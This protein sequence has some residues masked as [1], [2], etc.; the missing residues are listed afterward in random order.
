M[1]MQQTTPSTSRSAFPWAIIFASLIVLAALLAL[2]T[3]QVKRLIWKQQLLETIDECTHAAPVS[4]AEMERLLASEGSVEYRPVTVAGT[5][6]HQGERHFLATYNGEPG[7]YVYTPLQLDD[8]RF[9]LVNR[10][11][12]PY[13]RKD[14]ATREEGQLDGPV[15]ISGLARDRLAERPSS[16][17]PD[18][19]LAKNIFFWKDLGVMATTAGLPDR[20]AVIPFFVD[21]DKAPNPGGLPIGGVT[22]VDLPNSH[23]QYAVTWYGLALALVLVVGAYVWRWRF[24]KDIAP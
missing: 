13:G 21:A 11:F 14:A 16:F 18:N 15:T 7:F 19:D 9:I 12:V 4:L 2:G 24:P 23:L 3:W 22:I 1:T 6:M 10:G 17:V 8:G 20:G 5:F